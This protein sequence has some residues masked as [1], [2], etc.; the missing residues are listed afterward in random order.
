MKKWGHLLSISSLGSSGLAFLLALSPA[1][2]AGSPVKETKNIRSSKVLNLVAK[3]VPAKEDNALFLACQTIGLFMSSLQL[4]S[5]VTGVKPGSQAYLAGVTTGDKILLAKTD[6]EKVI[7][8]IKR[9]DKVYLANVPFQA[10]NTAASGHQYPITDLRL[11]HIKIIIDASG[12][13]HRHLGS[14]DKQ[15]WD[16]VREE[17]DK[18]C[19]GVER[20]NHQKFD[21]C[22]FN[23]QVQT[24]ERQT[25][26]QV[27]DKLNETIVLGNTDLPAALEAALSN[28]SEP[29]LV[30]LFTDGLAVSNGDCSSILISKLSRS[31][32]LRKSRVIFFQA[33][34]SAEGTAFM[35]KLD[36]VLKS[37][38]MD[39]HASSVLFQEASH[40]ILRTVKESLLK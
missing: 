7:L 28:V 30:L 31:D 38:G 14:S 15:R 32:V 9:K 34:H 17:V 5:T 25:A 23:E 20:E 16:W 27:S 22:L 4:P 33:G 11:F 6:K 13:M 10:T 40:G 26:R 35:V 36:E 39:K 19:T 37:A 29:I 8:H 2:L 3:T 21:L 12:S 24:F 1:A 18:F